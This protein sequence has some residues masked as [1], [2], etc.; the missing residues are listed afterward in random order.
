MAETI[1]DIIIEI[2]EYENSGERPGKTAFWNLGTRIEAAARA[3]VLAEREA[4]ARIV[5]DAGMMNIGIAS[6]I[7]ARK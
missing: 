4:C 6:K 1:D 2:G 5:D 3:A 7:R